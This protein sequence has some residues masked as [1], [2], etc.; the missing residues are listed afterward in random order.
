MR[1]LEVLVDPVEG[2]AVV[3][4]R[5]ERTQAVADQRDDVRLVDRA[6]QVLPD[7]DRRG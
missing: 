4:A 3:D 7:I 1:G 2:R 6:R 5:R